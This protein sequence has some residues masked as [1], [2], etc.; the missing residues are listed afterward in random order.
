M[1]TGNLTT[2]AAPPHVAAPQA[3]SVTRTAWPVLIAI[4]LCHMVNDILQSL[5]SAIYPL[6][7]EEF[8][9]SY[10][11]IGLMTFAFQ[12]TASLLQPVVG[13]VTDRRPM[14]QSLTVGMLCSFVGVL[15]LA[16]AGSYGM[17]L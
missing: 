13:M 11:Q 1:T 5:L 6:L 2:S 4:S 14:P 15:T 16:Q 17:L 8:A 9:L 10:A 12:V 3:S 7:K